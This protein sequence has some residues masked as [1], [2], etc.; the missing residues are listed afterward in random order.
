MGKRKCGLC[1]QNLDPHGYVVT[2]EEK[3]VLELCQA[4][5]KLHYDT[6][7]VILNKKDDERQ[8]LL[9]GETSVDSSIL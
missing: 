4:C 9:E 5:Y 2:H 6:I 1:S 3:E 8:K 7:G